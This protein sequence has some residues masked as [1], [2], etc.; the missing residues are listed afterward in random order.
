MIFVCILLALLSIAAV[1]LTVLYLIN[2]VKDRNRE[3]KNMSIAE[4][5]QRFTRDNIKVFAINNQGD[6]L[7]NHE[8]Y[9]LSYSAIGL[10]N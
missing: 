8:I 5:N 2:V 1:V 6:S 7:D 9:L 4:K 10:E 3:K